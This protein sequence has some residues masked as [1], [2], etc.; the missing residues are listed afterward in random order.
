M[1]RGL[2]STSGEDIV[3]V[4]VST[5]EVDIHDPCLCG[6]YNPS[7]LAEPFTVGASCG[8]LVGNMRTRSRAVK[9]IISIVPVLL[10]AGG[11]VHRGPAPARTPAPV[12][13]PV[14]MDRLLRRMEG[15]IEGLHSLTASFSA[16]VSDGRNGKKQRLSG[17]VAME[18]PGKMR[19]KASTAMLPT[20]L[21]VRLAGGE[22][23]IFIPREKA[24][25]GGRTRDFPVLPGIPDPL[26]I[27][28]V[29]WGSG[30]PEGTLNVMEIDGPEVVVYSIGGGRL[31][32][33][34]VFDR[35]SLRPVRYRYYGEGGICTREVLCNNY[36]PAGDGPVTIPR[37]I[38]VIS[39]APPVTVSLLLGRIR[40]NPP[41]KPA[42]FAFTAPPGTRVRPLEDLHP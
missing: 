41:L 10:A 21:D 42:V 36:F 3:V 38:V 13:P 20:L 16:L 28:S 30:E 25:Y 18:R 37:R 39:H 27:S 26:L 24:V 6:E 17:M 14:T 34:V 11:C 40:V 2:L 1:P 8:N 19:M 29:F 22:L 12:Y 9:A 33:K 23:S 4:A 31:I 15:G 5:S 7:P 32:K 35:A